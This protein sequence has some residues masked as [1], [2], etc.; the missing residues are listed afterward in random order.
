[1]NPGIRSAIINMM[2]R[3]H[4]DDAAAADSRADNERIPGWRS[5]DK[6]PARAAGSKELARQ[7]PSAAVSWACSTQSRR[8]GH[9]ASASI[10]DHSGD[11][12]LR[13]TALNKG[14]RRSVVA[15]RLLNWT[16]TLLFLLQRHVKPQ[17]PLKNN[18]TRALGADLNAGCAI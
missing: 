6:M 1:M 17:I 12:I 16:L 7:R 2:S 13:Q 9:V 10:R 8:L 14:S 18:L 5:P 15:P 11:H 4:F 3:L